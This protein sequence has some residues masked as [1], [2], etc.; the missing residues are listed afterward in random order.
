[1]IN[2]N[3][4]ARLLIEALPYIRRFTGPTIVVK[5]GGC[6]MTDPRGRASVAKDVLLLH[7]VGI[8]RA[9]P[10]GGPPDRRTDDAAGHSARVPRGPARPP[11]PRRSTSS[12]W[13]LSARSIV[14]W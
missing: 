1:M 3:D 10:G 8:A 5:V 4:T 11:T 2:T 9:R 13:C 7:S 6:P 12:A 14:S